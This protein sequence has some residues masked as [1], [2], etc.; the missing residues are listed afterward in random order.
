MGQCLKSGKTGNV[1]EINSLHCVIKN[2]VR[3][4]SSQ[5]ALFKEKTLLRK[6]GDGFMCPNKS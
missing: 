3:I 6:M 1:F 5:K 2:N 4:Q